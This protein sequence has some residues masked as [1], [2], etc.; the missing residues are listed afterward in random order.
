MRV[1]TA[2]QIRAAWEE[3]KSLP[4]ERR[5]W[6]RDQVCELVEATG[7]IDAAEAFGF[8]LGLQTARV[9]LR[10]SGIIGSACVN[11]EDVL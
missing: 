4:I 7:R 10:Q 6:D 3:I 2:S 11:P 5:P 8:N 9:V 1:P